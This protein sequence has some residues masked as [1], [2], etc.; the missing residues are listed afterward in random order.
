MNYSNSES[1][2]Q[3]SE[4][5]D[6]SFYDK[7][8]TLCGIALKYADKLKDL[9]VQKST[10][11]YVTLCS[12][13]INEV[14]KFIAIKK[15]HFLP[16]VQSLSEKEDGGHNCASCSGGCTV[17]HD[18]QLQELKQSLLQLKDVIYRVQMVALPLYSDSIYPD[19]YRLLRNHMAL[20]ENTLTELFSVEQTQLIPKI[21]D[22][23]K[24]INA[25]R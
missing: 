17:Q 12:R 15:D 5:L 25:L 1:L 22:A 6:K 4:R 7:I 8:N 2:K 24:N 10:S 21:V 9:E 3:L 16:Y 19:V 13:L 18:L 23:Q 11:Q 14:Q 20:I